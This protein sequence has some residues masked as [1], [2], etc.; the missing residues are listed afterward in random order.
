MSM[1]DRKTWPVLLTY[2]DT[3]QGH[4]GAIYLATGWE[5]D[6][7]GGGW[8]YYDPKTDRQ[9]A[10]IQDGHFIPCPKGWEARRTLKHRFVSHAPAASSDAADIQSDEGGSQLTLVLQ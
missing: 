6:G 4:T 2:A 9:L 3:G 7:D 5:P 8:N 10:S 1:L